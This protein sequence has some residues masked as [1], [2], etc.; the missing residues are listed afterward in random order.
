M[1]LCH[2]HL[3]V[4]AYCATVKQFKKTQKNYFELQVWMLSKKT[5]HI[6]PTH[7]P[8]YVLLKF[9]LSVLY[10]NWLKQPCT[11]TRPICHNKE[12]FA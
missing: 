8:S 12:A 2:P 5:I 10:L 9:V 6:R 3:I 7:S 4:M 11:I 1:E